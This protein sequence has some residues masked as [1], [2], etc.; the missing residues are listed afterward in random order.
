MKEIIAFIIAVTM[1]PV[2]C[3]CGPDPAKEIIG[4]WDGTES[5]DN[6]NSTYSYVFYEGG[7][8]DQYR[9]KDGEEKEDYYTSG[10]GTWSIVDDSNL[11][12]VDYAVGATTFEFELE[13]GTLILDGETF[14][15]GDI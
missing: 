11:R 5:V 13:D 7:A 8:Y 6:A 14:T 4:R 2:T 10:H 3:A 15:K 1:M 12:I 9:N